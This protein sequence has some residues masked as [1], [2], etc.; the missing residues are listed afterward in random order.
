M[1]ILSASGIH[2]GGVGYIVPYGTCPIW[3]I[4]YTRFGVMGW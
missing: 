2:G 4:F 1:D 3:P